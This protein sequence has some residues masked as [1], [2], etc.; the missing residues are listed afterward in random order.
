MTRDVIERV[1]FL[2]ESEFGKIRRLNKWVGIFVTVLFPIIIGLLISSFGKLTNIDPLL[3]WIP[4][5]LIL[6]MHIILALIF[7]SSPQLVQQE[8]FEAESIYSANNQLIDQRD[9]YEWD[10]RY[11]DIL[12]ETS[13][14]W[15]NLLNT[16]LAR[17]VEEESELE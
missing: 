12:A 7:I 16:Y 2:A 11:L 3:F 9:A 14:Q 17:N 8:Y 1:K 15:I 4:F 10:L 13:Y 6:I 5:S